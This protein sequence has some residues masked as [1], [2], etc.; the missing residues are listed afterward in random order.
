MHAARACG[1]E[2]AR[3]VGNLK[4]RHTP[5]ATAIRQRDMTTSIWRNQP[6]TSVNGKARVIAGF[7]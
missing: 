2:R 4:K 7:K 5:Q 6:C 1:Q 3:V